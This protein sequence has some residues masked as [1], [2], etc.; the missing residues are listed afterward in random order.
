MQQ[1]ARTEFLVDLYDRPR[2][3]VIVL[4]IWVASWVHKLFTK[5]GQVLSAT[6]YLEAAEL[7]A[8]TEK[9]QLNLNLRKLMTHSLYKRARALLSVRGNSVTA[10]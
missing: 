9:Q 7:P 5:T 6:L 8:V 4:S 1:F 2:A 3:F 10:L